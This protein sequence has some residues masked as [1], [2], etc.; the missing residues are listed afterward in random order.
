M[1]V[2]Q[3]RAFCLVAQR[4]TLFHAAAMLKCSP[5]AISLRINRLEKDVGAKLFNRRPNKLI[6]TDKGKLFLRDAARI[7]QELEASIALLHRG[8]E[9]CAGDVSV[10]VGNDTAHLLAPKVAAFVKENPS[11]NLSIL[12]RPS[13]SQVFELVMDGEVDI[14]IGRFPNLPRTLQKISLVSSGLVAIYPKIHPLSARGH[15]S[16]QDL[17][18]HGL[19]VLHR[20]STTRRIIDQAFS[21]NSLKMKTVLEAGDCSVIREY[22]KQRVGVGLIHDTCVRG[23]KDSSCRISDVRHIFGQSDLS[24]IYQKNNPLGLAHKKFIKIIQAIFDPGD[25]RQAALPPQ[26]TLS[27]GGDLSRKEAR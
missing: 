6:L 24:L 9:I 4:G 17:A 14:G 12:S 25:R 26:R 27:A 3:L 8:D 19:V 21:K 2:R 11:V 5:A 10:A 16:L 1:D 23:E 15:L 7:L 22:V 13:S 18:S 20:R